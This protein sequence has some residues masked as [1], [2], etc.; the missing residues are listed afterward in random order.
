MIDHADVGWGEVGRAPA[1]C[2]SALQHL[3]A[4]FGAEAEPI[5]DAGPLPSSAI[6]AVADLQLA[7]VD[8]RDIPPTVYNRPNGALDDVGGAIVS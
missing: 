2:G 4:D 7:V 6:E 1:D 5:G 3:R 8:N